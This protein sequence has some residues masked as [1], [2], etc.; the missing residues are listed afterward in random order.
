MGQNINLTPEILE[1]IRVDQSFLNQTKDTFGANETLSLLFVS[2]SNDKIDSI[3]LQDSD[4]GQ[5]YTISGDNLKNYLT[6]AQYNALM[7]ENTDKTD[8]PDVINNPQNVVL[9]VA[10][11]AIDEV[12]NVEG[13][14]E[15]EN[16]NATAPTQGSDAI[17]AEIDKLEKQREANQAV[18]ASLKEQIDTLKDKIEV[19]IKDA[20]ADMEK[21]AEED[22]EKIN[23]DVQA[24]IK[25]FQEA[26]MNGEDVT[27]D[28]LAAD[29]KGILAQ[30]NLSDGFCSAVSNLLLADTNMNLMNNLL[31]QLASKNQLDKSLSSMIDDKTKEFDTAKAAEEAAAA[32]KSCDPIGFQ[33]DGIDTDGDGTVGKVQFDFFYDEDNDGKINSLNDFVGAKADKAGEDGWSEIEN[34]DGVGGDADGKITA[35]ELNNANI[36]VMVT[37]ENGKQYAMDVN[38]FEEK[39][40]EIAIGKDDI[41]AGD[42]G[43]SANVGPKNFNADGDNELL[44]SFNLT[45][46]RQALSGYQTSDT[47]DWLVNNYSS[48]MD[49]DALEAEGVDVSNVQATG[50]VDGVNDVQN[51]YDEYINEYRNVIIPQ[52]Q[53]E[54]KQAYAQLT[55]NNAFVEILRDLAVET[56]K[57]E[58]AKIEAKYEEQL[59][60]AEAAEETPEGEEALEE[61]V[62]EDT[63]PVVEE[64]EVPQD[65]TPEV[66]PQLTRDGD[67]PFDFELLFK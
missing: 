13:V 66:E 20:L 32:A 16:V 17:K 67:E 6:D 53:E 52:L 55:T 24:A 31:D 63:T 36:K 33:L 2:T 15:A 46:G 49:L 7:S 42:E 34:L 51:E 62:A 26:K 22:E 54:I 61:E 25:E 23:E 18:M 1:K 35:D 65:A 9:D 40:G 56:A 38:E 48:V 19:L 59:E 45:V 21:K 8:E 37:D 14:E 27:P 10:N 47:E 39:F 57:N 12:G 50:E 41:E 64:P 29:I 4:G 43:F 58:G 44:S 5:Q 28:Q 60:A 30:N 3:T 11:E